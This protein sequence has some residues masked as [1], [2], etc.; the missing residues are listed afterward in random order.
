MTLP[1]RLVSL[2]DVMKSLDGGQFALDFQAVT[3]FSQ[4]LTDAGPEANHCFPVPT[5]E[6]LRQHV[7][8]LLTECQRMN[9][10]GA[11][12]SLRR[13]QQQMYHCS[14]AGR[15][16]NVGAIEVDP[17]HAAAFR[18][19]FAEVGGRIQDELRGRVF[20]SLTAAESE[21]YEPADPLFGAVVE[22]EFPGCSFDISEAGKCL[23]VGA[24]TASVFHA[25]RAAEAA[26]SVLGAKLGATITNDNG[27]G[28][29]LGILIANMKP[30]I[31]VLPK[32]PRQDA[33]LK[34]HARMHSCN[35]AYRT[36]AAHPAAKYTETEADTAFRATRSFM[37][38]FAE[39][40][41]S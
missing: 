31:E 35:R 27:E 29:P 2:W 30:K 15:S 10:P 19:A 20:L 40:L 32:G 7:D 26:A 23:A 25:M 41:R 28:L 17:N 37:Q 4:L 39:V 13:A 12:A 34:V 18:G 5:F 1:K 16:G 11:A 22:T 14:A 21:L 36:K 33:W 24:Y 3:S 8:G 6:I 38:E 9:L